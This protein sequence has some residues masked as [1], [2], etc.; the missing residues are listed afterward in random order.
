MRIWAVVTSAILAWC[1][2]A[3]SQGTGGGGKSASSV[4]LPPPKP[5]QLPRAGEK[6]VDPTFGT[7]IL[8][9]TDRGD[10]EQATHAYSL[11][12]AFNCTNTRFIVHLSN[13]DWTLY[14]FEPGAFAS[15]KV[16][17]VCCPPGG[18][19][20]NL[21][22]SMWHPTDPDT[23]Y[24]LEPSSER[25]RL[26]AYNVTTQQYKLVHDF[27]GAV[28]TGGYPNSLSMSE[29]GRYL[30]FYASRTGG[31]DT[32]EI[33]VVYNVQTQAVYTYDFGV[34]KAVR[35]I[36][37]MFIDKTG[38]YAVIQAGYPSEGKTIL[39]V[40]NFGFGSVEPLVFNSSDRP[41]G[42][43][44]LGKS[45]MI[46]PDGWEGNRFLFRSLVSP[47]AWRPV[48]VIPRKGGLIQYQTDSHSSMNQSDP[49][50][51]IWS[52]YTASRLTSWQPHSGKIFKAPGF[53]RVS[54]GHL[55]PDGVRQNGVDLAKALGIPSAR[56]QWWYDARADTLFVWLDG[57]AD[58]RDP[59]MYVV[60]FDW[61]PFQDE[62][63]QVWTD[64]PNN[65]TKVRRLAHHQSHWA[66]TSTYLDGPRASIDRS[67]RYVIFTSNWGGSGHRDVFVLRISQ[68]PRGAGV[69]R[70]P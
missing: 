54:L 33:A 36:H 12:S 19:T 25:R 16:R 51:Y 47:H 26:F 34:R 67:G 64:S 7:E 9:V 60:P 52:N 22:N 28:A 21:E 46:N 70:E 49:R 35:N 61:R 18:A 38:S 66:N 59:K 65:L 13:A 2:L 27:T 39:W 8:R 56:G 50:F 55:P 15:K 63:V 58:P 20:L 48:F 45:A 44:V 53:T 4:I 30:G 10:A 29:D 62:I 11:W 68:T 40:W 6:F 14:D 43:F 17:R 42:H 41:G 32:G 5:L 3:L 57:D 69:V 31:Q 24:A 1:A 23:L 37:S